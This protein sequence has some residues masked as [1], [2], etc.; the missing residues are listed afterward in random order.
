MTRS[1]APAPALAPSPAP[2]DVPG[3]GPGPGPGLGSGLI[4]LLFCLPLPPMVMT[5]CI[6]I[7]PVNG[8]TDI[9]RLVR[10][11]DQIGP[12]GQTGHKITLATKPH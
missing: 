6:S 3:P 11:Q 5:H 4:L 7:L 2:A 12:I 9:Q 1:I 8:Y 10:P